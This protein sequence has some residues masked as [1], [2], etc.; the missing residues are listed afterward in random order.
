VKGTKGE[1]SSLVLDGKIEPDSAAGFFGEII[2]GSSLVGLG[3]PRG[4][5]SDF[6]ALAQLTV[7]MRR[8]SASRDGPAV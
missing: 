7:P 8:E 4:S 3:A 6:H 5:P 2:V 1:P